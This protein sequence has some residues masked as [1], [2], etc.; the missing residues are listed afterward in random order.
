MII[1]YIVY[2]GKKY[3]INRVYWFGSGD[4]AIYEFT[5]LNDEVVDFEVKPDEKLTD[6][7]EVYF[8]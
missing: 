4:C 1:V 6:K 5:N 8:E 7:V 3:Y 2:Y